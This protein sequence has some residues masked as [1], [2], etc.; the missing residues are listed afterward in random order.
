VAEDKSNTGIVVDKGVPAISV[1]PVKKEA[2][3]D[4]TILVD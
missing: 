2:A 4:S 3:P 1:I